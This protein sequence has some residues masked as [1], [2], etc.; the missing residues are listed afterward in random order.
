MCIRDSVNNVIQFTITLGTIF[1][2]LIIIWAGFKLV[3]SAGNPSAM[4]SAKKI[5]TNVLIGFVLLLTAFLI[6]NTILGVIINGPD[7]AN[8]LNWQ[9]IECIRPNAPTLTD[10]GE[11][12]FQA[13]DIFVENNDGWYRGVYTENDIPATRCS[14]A[15]AC[16]AAVQACTEAGLSAVYDNQI[17]GI[18]E[19]ALPPGG[20]NS[21]GGNYTGALAQCSPS[22]TA[23]SVEALRAAGYNESQ[24]NIM[25]CIAITESSGNPSV[26]P[27]NERHPGS[28]SSACG[29]FQITQ[30]T[31]NTYRP[32]GSCSDWRSNCQNAA[33]NRQVALTLVRNNGYRDW[34][35]P[36]CNNKAAACVR[37]YQ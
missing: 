37:A 33:C 30:T 18:V 12:E 23:C 16:A 26:G 4:Q 13:L 34:T 36:N 8:L 11:P 20:T 31:W 29:L 19:C 28:N 5:I 25:S 27:Y 21:G 35:C 17:P 1:A 2:T 10:Q 9:E 32:S 7:R 22:N 3:T 24:A 14:S 15:D 6:V